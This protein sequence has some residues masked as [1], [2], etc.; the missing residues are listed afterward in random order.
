MKWY[1]YLI[2]RFQEYKW[3][4]FI[5]FI[6]SFIVGAIEYILGHRPNIGLY[7]FLTVLLLWAFVWIIASVLYRKNLKK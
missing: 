5:P 1:D 7:V 2:L 3:Y 6:V 4:L